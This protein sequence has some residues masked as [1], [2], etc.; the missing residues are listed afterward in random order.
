MS[1]SRSFQRLSFE[2][3]VREALATVE[4][5]LAL[6]RKPSLAADV[7]HEYGAKYALVDATTNAAI[8]AYVTCLGKLGLDEAAL[9]GL[10]GTKPAT[11]RFEASISREFLKEVVVDVPSNASHELKEEVV[12]EEGGE[13]S[14]KTTTTKV[15]KVVKHVTEYHWEVTVDWSLSVYSGTAVGDKAI[16]KSR[17]CKTAIITRSKGALEFAACPPAELSLSW[18]LRQIDT[19]DFAS[20]FKVDTEDEKTKTPRRNE[21][22]DGA[23]DFAARLQLWCR[24]VRGFVHA[25]LKSILQRPN[26]AVSVPGGDG[27]TMKK[28]LA[29]GREHPIFNPVL[30]LMDDNVAPSAGDEVGGS[31]E[32]EGILGL[33]LSA[34]GHDN[35]HTVLLLPGDTSKLLIEHARTIDE[36]IEGLEQAWPPGDSDGVLSVAEATLMLLGCDHAA[37]LAAQYA[38]AMEYVESMMEG[39]LIAAI[40]KRLTPDDLDAFVEYHNN[41]LLTPKPQPFS[42]AIR[43]PNHYPVGL[44]IIESKSEDRSFPSRSKAPSREN[45]YVHTHSREVIATSSLKIPLSAAT[46]LDMTG[47]QYLHGYMNHRFGAAHKSHRLVARARQFSAFILIVG[48]TTDGSTLDPKDTII[49][50]N[51]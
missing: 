22:V 29:V 32:R 9:R 42:H 25:R 13:D 15:M 38:D 41:R 36:A 10:D 28:L 3:K 48:T 19:D 35:G 47:W 45:E 17:T 5:T 46:V 12:A 37:E 31:L 50:Q 20:N 8:A 44:L 40:G 7:D 34:G 18:L 2:R 26:P 33:K 43:C 24:E 23:L 51:K 6:E 39:S 21:A 11:L 1:L 49:V 14:K 27:P 16:V 30:P 4:R